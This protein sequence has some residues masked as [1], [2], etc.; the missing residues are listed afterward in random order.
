MKRIFLFLVFCYLRTTAQVT[1]IPWPSSEDIF[2]IDRK[3]SNILICGMESNLAKCYGDCNTL[4]PV[5]LPVFTEQSRLFTV[6]RPDSNYIYLNYNAIPYI[7]QIWRSKN[8]GASWSKMLDTNYNGLTPVNLHFFDSLNGVAICNF[9]MTFKTNDA[10]ETFTMGT[11][12]NKYPTINAVGYKDSTLIYGDQSGSGY[13][14]KDKGVTWNPL[15]DFG[16]ARPP[17]DFYFLNKDTVFSISYSNS[18]DKTIYFLKSF[19][20]GNNWQSRSFPESNPLGT[21]PPEDFFLKVH[22][23]NA[24]EIYILARTGLVGYD[25]AGKGVILKSTDLGQTWTRFTTPFNANLNDIEF[26]NDSIALVCGNGGLLFKWNTRQSIFTTSIKETKADNALLTLYP[27]PA[28]ESFKIELKGVFENTAEVR[29][30]GIDG[31][32]LLHFKNHDLQNGIDLFGLQPGVYLVEVK[33]K[34][35]T[36]FSKLIKE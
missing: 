4:I 16:Y 7:Q 36:T 11:W 29:I 6:N 8:A 30:C 17:F 32:T 15:Y 5:N 31:R 13:I 9:F 22:A 24:N 27:N 33:G 1:V 14:T 21:I 28:S 26:L 2:S 34:S 25:Y 20:G 10:M 19:N 3:G 18:L 23:Q 35:F 12:N